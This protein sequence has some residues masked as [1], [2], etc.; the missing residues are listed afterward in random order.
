MRKILVMM[1][2]AAMAFA[3]CS[4]DIVKETNRG[5]AIDFR[6][7]TQSR[8]TET[9]SANLSTFYV[10]ALNDLEENYFNNVAY[11]KVNEYFCSS[12]E[13]YWPGD[14][15]S[16]D[17]YAYA[18]SSHMLGADITIDNSS[19]K[20]QNFSPAAKINQQ[21][22]FITA[23]ATG[24]N[25]D[26]ADGLA[27]IFNHQLA[28]IEINAQN[29]N[30]GYVYNIK[31]VRITQ[32]VS[33]GDFDF[34]TSE[35]ALD[36]KHKSIYEATYDI[37]VTLDSYAKNIMEAKG[38]NAMLLPQQ[39]VQWEPESDPTNDQ[40][41]AYISVYTKITSS[42]GSQIFPKTA[43]EYAWVAVPINT[44]WKAGNKYVYTLDFTNGAGY[45]DPLYGP[46]QLVL[47]QKINFDVKITPWEEKSTIDPVVGVWHINKVHVIEYSKSRDETTEEI[48]DD[49]TVIE[50]SLEISYLEFEF[51]SS[52]EVYFNDE[53]GKHLATLVA[54]DGKLYATDE[55]DLK[56]YFEWP[57][58][59]KTTLRFV[60][61][62]EDNNYIF[63]Y[64]LYYEKI[65]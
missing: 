31:G 57:D 11:T 24:N 26:A 16:L 1:G 2:I 53:Y 35:W 6:V 8:G 28:Q 64:H 17:F 15:S 39:L 47:G 45:T 63:K 52:T 50:E 55:V 27:L 4:K 21:H 12:P 42:T 13:Y 7:A 10:T 49:K 62:S 59:N 5:R 33:K 36:T 34:S 46:A 51:I 48:I 14:G 38:E 32:P 19:K 23:F 9:N 20:L 30:E 22:D 29:A 61:F 60:M 41:G 65:N 18:P 58:E 56:I 3:S 43:D 40:K 44:E 37:P 25:E 54:K